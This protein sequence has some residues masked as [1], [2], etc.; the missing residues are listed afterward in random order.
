VSRASEYAYVHKRWPTRRI[1]LLRTVQIRIAPNQELDNL[2]WIQSPYSFS[3]A[4]QL[5]TTV[6]GA[7]VVSS[8]GETTRKR[9]PLPVTT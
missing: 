5:V 7:T 9:W 8:R 1:L 3:P 2:N 6:M 4:A